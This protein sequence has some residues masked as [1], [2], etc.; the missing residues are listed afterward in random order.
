VA[1]DRLLFLLGLGRTFKR[2]R[3]RFSAG[4]YLL[5]RIELSCA[6]KLLVLYGG[7]AVWSLSNSLQSALGGHAGLPVA[8]SKLEHGQ[9]RRV[10]AGKRDELE[11]VAHSIEVALEVRNG[12]VVKILS[13]IK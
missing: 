5:H 9:V 13:P 11:F 8:A 6:H 1:E 2:H 12:G 7:V 10:E 4:D 3:R